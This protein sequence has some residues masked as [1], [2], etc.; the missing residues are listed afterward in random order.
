MVAARHQ[1]EG[2]HAIPGQK[3]SRLTQ[4]IQGIQGLILDEQARRRQ[5]KF[6]QKLPATLSLTDAATSVTADQQNSPPGIGLVQRGDPTQ[7]AGVAGR[8][9]VV[10]QARAQHHDPVPI[11]PGNRGVARNAPNLPQ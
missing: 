3:T 11:N 7:P 8:D 4:I 10:D 5:P 6:K 9:L 1:H 2:P